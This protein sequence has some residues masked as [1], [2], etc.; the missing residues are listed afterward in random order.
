MNVHLLRYNH[1]SNRRSPQSKSKGVCALKIT[2][3]LSN[4]GVG[5]GTSQYLSH[6]AC[7]SLIARPVSERPCPAKR[8][9]V[10]WNRVQFAR[11]TRE[12]KGDSG[13]SRS[14]GIWRM[15]IYRSRSIRSYATKVFG[16]LHS[17]GTHLYRMPRG[18]LGLA[19]GLAGHIS[20]D[21]R[22]EEK[23]NCLQV[24][25]TCE[26]GW[27]RS[28]WV[29]LNLKLGHAHTPDVMVGHRATAATAARLKGQWKEEE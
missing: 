12:A 3:L 24:T 2:L 21:S 5:I 26:C 11:S 14:I 9:R 22:Q 7:S 10:E 25:G 20:R 8:R 16:G 6:T 27:A 4:G 15:W 1:M 29:S 23:R 28:N 18:R 17:T 19:S 13:R